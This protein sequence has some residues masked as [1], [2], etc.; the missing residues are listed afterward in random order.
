MFRIQFM[1]EA[2]N[3][4]R[5]IKRYHAAAIVDAIERRLAQEPERITRGSIKRLRGP[6]HATFRLRVGNYR[7]FY[8]VREDRVEILRILH[9]SETGSFYQEP[10]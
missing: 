2:A 9:K 4:L 8:D 5:R 1:P 3:D 7:I 6:Q 10:K